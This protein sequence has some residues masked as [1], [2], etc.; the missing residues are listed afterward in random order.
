MEPERQS[1]P[2]VD[3]DG[4]ITGLLG[5]VE[6]TYYALLLELQRFHDERDENERHYFASELLHFVFANEQHSDLFDEVD[7]GKQ[8]AYTVDKSCH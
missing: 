6:T 2:T 4:D 7:Q 1:D 3:E 5:N 8:R